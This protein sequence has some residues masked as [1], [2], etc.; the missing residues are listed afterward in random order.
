MRQRAPDS[1]A[2]TRLPGPQLELIF[3]LQAAW[4]ARNVEITLLSW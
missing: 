1:A 3:H 4:L 2:P